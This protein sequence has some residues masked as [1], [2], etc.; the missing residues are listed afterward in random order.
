MLD[1][2]KLS[3]PSR[4]EILREQISTPYLYH[5]NDYMTIAKGK[6]RQLLNHASACIAPEQCLLHSMSEYMRG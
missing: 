1:L 6:Q 4:P 3:P 2:P 5:M